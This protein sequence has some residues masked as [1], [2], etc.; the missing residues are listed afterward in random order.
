MPDNTPQEPTGT[1]G[2]GEGR[3]PESV[4]S[5]PPLPP[6][7]LTEADRA[8]LTNAGVSA[9]TLSA[10]NAT[11]VPEGIRFRL[12][13]LT[14]PEPFD[15]LML[16]TERRAELAESYRLAGKTGRPPKYLGAPGRGG[17]LWCPTERPTAATVLF[18][19]GTKGHLAA[20]SWAGPDIEVIG[21]NGCWG[22]SV[23]GGKS[24]PHPAI[25][26]V[27]GRRV[28]VA[29]DADVRTNPDVNGAGAQLKLHLDA[30]GAAGVLFASV[31]V[32]SESIDDVLGQTPEG[33][34]PAWLD[35]LVADATELK[36]MTAA[37][38]TRINAYSDQQAGQHELAGSEPLPAI[39]KD[40][41]AAFAAVNAEGLRYDAVAA[42]WATWTGVRWDHRAGGALAQAQW[43]RFVDTGPPVFEE[44]M[45]SGV[46]IRT[47][48][49]KWMGEH[50]RIGAVLGHAQSMHPLLVTD[51]GVWDANPYLMAFPN[52]TLDLSTLEFRGSWPGDMLTQV[53]GTHYD[54]DAVAPMWDA[55]IAWALP[56]EQV[57]AFLRR[58]L[59]Y[60][61]LGVVNHHLLPCL[62][63]SGRNGKGTLI[64]VISSVLGDHAGQAN[65]RLIVAGRDPHDTDAGTV[66][67]KRLAFFQETGSGTRWDANRL[68][69]LTGG[70]PGNVRELYGMP[71]VV[72][73]QHTLI[74]G[75][76]HRPNVPAGEAAFWRRYRE[77]PFVNSVGQGK[78]RPVDIA[79]VERE[80][81]GVLNWLIGGLADY[82][83][84]V[85]AGGD[86]MAQ[87]D[88]VATAGAEAR[89]E[90][91]EFSS[92]LS[93]RYIVTG[94]SQDRLQV[95]D[96]WDRWDGHRRREGIPNTP[97]RA[98]RLVPDAVI[99]ESDGQV[100]R[101]VDPH[102]RR[103]WLVGIRQIQGTQA[104][105][106]A[107][108]GP[109][110]APGDANLGSKPDLGGFGSQA[111]TAGQGPEAT[112]T[113]Q[114]TQL[115]R[116]QDDENIE[117]G[118]EGKSVQPY[119][120]KMGTGSL[121]SETPPN[122]APDQPGPKISDLRRFASQ[123]EF[124]SLP[125][126]TG[127]VVALDLEGGDIKL[128]YTTPAG[129]YPRL[130]G[131][132]PVGERS[133][134]P[135]G[136]TGDIRDAIRAAREAG[137]VV[138]HN[139][140]RFDA[141]VL[142]RAAAALGVPGIDTLK[143]AREG[144]GFDTMAFDPLINPPPLHVKPERAMQDYSLEKTCARWG[145]PGKTDHLPDLAKKHG[146]Y[147]QI[148]LDDREYQDYLRGDV[149][150][151]GALFR[152]MAPK[153]NAYAMREMRVTAVAGVMSAAG[154]EVD[155]ELLAQR[156]KETAGHKAALIERLSAD[157]GIKA[158][159]KDGKPSAAP[160]STEAGRAGIVE[161]FGRLGVHPQDLPRT[162]EGAPAVGGDQMRELALTY[163]D[164]PDI[165]RLCAIVAG[166]SGSRT[167]YETAHKYTHPDGRVHP[168][169]LTL[170][171]SGR[172]SVIK[173]GMTVYGKRGGRVVER[174]VF[175]A[176]EGHRLIA[177]DLSQ[178]DMR[179]L[180]AH[181]QDPDYIRLF[182][183]GRD[184]HAETALAVFG[185]ATMREEAK[186][187]NHGWN[188]GQTPGGMNATSGV[189][190]ELAERFDA[191][192]WAQFPGLCA[193]R[194]G[195][196]DHARSGGLLDNGFGRIMRPDP[197]RAHTQGPALMGQG[198]ARDLMMKVILD[199]PDDIVRMLRIQVH[200]EIVLE[201]PEQ[202]VAEVSE[203]V[204]AAMT[205][206]WAPPHGS[207]PVPIIGDV[208]KPG[209]S[210]ADCYAK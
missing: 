16:S 101:W 163:R 159:R 55:F 97:P 4:T 47:R 66:F 133:P 92:W 15:Q 57:R 27:A 176:A 11:S 142:N 104:P 112:L 85:N 86:P 184:I 80:L 136:H 28:V 94:S 70:D 12:P 131:I 158:L 9:A 78:E 100:S 61:M 41:A 62:V 196:R 64:R 128:R 40:V 148:P 156:R 150:A 84:L 188:Y 167:V 146:G 81:P 71:R 102:T 77:I 22:W 25:G 107:P 193:Y 26:R 185:D 1:E 209:K 111:E 121:E 203:I 30:Y 143:M 48:A 157:Y 140:Y 18:V 182:Q 118:E 110:S 134:K 174:Q 200:D 149:D 53:A 33:E 50:R 72:R 60:S 74:L 35:K 5:G 187:C 177:A 207:I 46:P 171:A 179:A 10:V 123:P 127:Q 8:S 161:A 192:M 189:P 88:A 75:T 32:G 151:H 6:Q 126:F 59:G 129:D 52:G 114:A 51:P 202:D 7:E 44:R 98:S 135:Y 138:G 186:P 39:D 154:I 194:E 106:P 117:G 90:G 19:E 99:G 91:S 67:G 89:A 164:R 105:T 116:S 145:V 95:G 206:D 21:I 139:W 96:L 166:L 175:R 144:K 208:S 198:C 190:L 201:I 169:I 38:R 31:G 93:E 119:R 141:P 87:P 13:D 29:L 160:Q 65:E 173:P 137:M 115:L 197:T 124:A 183:S 180:A 14:H 83:S 168:E 23:G 210:W 37:E 191:G 79:I 34:R 181:S 42:R 20:A 3:G 113:T 82:W 103:K 45:V 49:A 58:I 76:N 68:K 165:L 130:V 199:L 36:V 54:P 109:A 43:Q 195:V 204:R 170:Q 155:P 69:D 63:G 162:G 125:D 172:W 205:F 120:E 17:A 178:I 56:D 2:L 108:H 73:A 152:A 147:D 132:G 153:I 24:T 122:V